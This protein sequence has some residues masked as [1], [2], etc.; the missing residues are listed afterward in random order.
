MARAVGYC[1]AGYEVVNGVD[2]ALC[3]DYVNATQPVGHGDR[4]IT[5]RVAI[6]ADNV[7]CEPP[8]LPLSKS[9]KTKH[10]HGVAN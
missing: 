1:R 2:V 5:L 10:L 4:R 6:A 3:L 8:Q 9:L 7:G